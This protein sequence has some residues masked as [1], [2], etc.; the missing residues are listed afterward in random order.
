M[1]A[2]RS[3]SFLLISARQI[4]FQPERH[5]LRRSAEERG[6]ARQEDDKEEVGEG[7]VHR[8]SG[9]GKKEKIFFRKMKQDA[10]C[11]AGRLLRRKCRK[12]IIVFS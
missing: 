9:P 4:L 12:N 5:R 2:D 6:A 1:K 8:Q 3:F 11:L 7:R 10:N